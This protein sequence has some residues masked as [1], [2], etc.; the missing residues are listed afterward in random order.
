[1]AHKGS[2]ANL[3]EHSLFTNHEVQFMAQLLEEGHILLLLAMQYD[4]AVF[5]KSF[6]NKEFDLFVFD[7]KSSLVKFDEHVWILTSLLQP[8][9]IKSSL[10]S[11][12]IEQAAA[13]TH[14]SL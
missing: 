9:I 4:C 2:D 11:A 7:F 14:F 3:L 10:V 12:I 5:V 13:I 8:K 1:M 6:E